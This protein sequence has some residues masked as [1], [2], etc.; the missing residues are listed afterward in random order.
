MANELEI[1]RSKEMPLPKFCTHSKGASSN[2]GAISLTTERR[3]KCLSVVP[4]SI[5]NNAGLR[6]PSYHKYESYTFQ[7]VY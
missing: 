4:S 2:K 7:R 6:A 1:S 5:L 3:H